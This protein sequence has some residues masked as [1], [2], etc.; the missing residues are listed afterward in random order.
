MLK[1]RLQ[2]LSLSAIL[3]RIKI[4]KIKKYKLSVKNVKRIN[5]IYKC[6]CIPHVFEINNTNSQHLN[7]TTSK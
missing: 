4:L 5:I 3:I 1:N 2:P 7:M 6:L